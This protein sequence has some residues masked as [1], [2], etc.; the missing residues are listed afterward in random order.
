M[1]YSGIAVGGPFHGKPIHHGLQTLKIARNKLSGKV[2]L[3]VGPDTE[4]IRVDEYRYQRG[5][6]VWKE[7]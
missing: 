2:V 1:L 7:K 3:W 6:W 5:R 4:E